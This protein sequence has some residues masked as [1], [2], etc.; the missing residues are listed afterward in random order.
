MMVVNSFSL[1]ERKNDLSTDIN[2]R[3][4]RVVTFKYPSEQK[5]LA[6]ESC[7]YPICADVAIGEP[8]DISCC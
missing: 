1:W 3:R 6:G 4:S 8:L 5:L 2:Q 7:V